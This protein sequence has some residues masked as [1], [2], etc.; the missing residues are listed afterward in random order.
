MSDLREAISA[1]PKPGSYGTYLGEGRMMVAVTWGG[2]LLTPAD[3]MSLTPELVTHGIYEPAF[4]RYLMR[5][6][7]PGMRV[8]DVG[9]NIGMHTVLMAG[10]VGTTGRVLAYEPSPDVLTSCERTWP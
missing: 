7:K 5:T 10:W 8:V 6:L 4:T 9:A 1:Q 2:P 3:D